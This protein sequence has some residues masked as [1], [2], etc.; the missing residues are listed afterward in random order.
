MPNFEILC[1]YNKTIMQRFCQVYITVQRFLNN[2][3]VR[4]KERFLHQILFRCL[5]TA[6]ECIGEFF[7]SILRPLVESFWDFK[8]QSKSIFSSV[9]FSQKI[10]GSSVD[11]SVV[12]AVL[13]DDNVSACR[14]TQG[15]VNHKFC[16]VE[17]SS[18]GNMQKYVLGTFE[19]YYLSHSIF[20]W[21]MN[22]SVSYSM[23][24]VLCLSFRH[25]T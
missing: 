19:T 2:I 5:D 15:V 23:P 6:I 25:I 11:F 17:F 3:C 4:I 20:F 24:E 12:L 22:Y 18:F 13:K 14:Q 8:A 16:H 9:S 7:V 1:K 10:M 21:K